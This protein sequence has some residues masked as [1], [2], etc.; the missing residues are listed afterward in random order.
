MQGMTRR[1]WLGTMGSLPLLGGLTNLGVTRWRSLWA[2][3]GPRFRRVPARTLIQQRHLPNVPLVTHEGKSVRFYDD[4]V[5]DKK[6]VI[7]FLD[8]QTLP[9]S[10]TVTRNL[11]A[12]QGYFGA[13]V[14]RDIHFYS[15][16][17]NPQ[18]TPAMLKTWA[19]QYDVRP[20][21]LFLTGRQADVQKLR[22]AL[23][24]A[25]PQ[26]AEDSDPRYILGVL[27][28]GIEPEMRWAQ[29]QAKGRPRAIAHHLQLDFGDDPADPNP[30]PLWSCDRIL[31]ELS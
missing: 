19:E 30:P 29:C 8:T 4:L 31:E 17:F 10:E 7:N 1:Q 13:R 16:S 23:G 28:T 3:G 2:R 14:G 5:K 21:W 11:R 6:V 27:R 18:D 26:P 24:F 22:R 20:G 15:V 25:I 9:E 12:L